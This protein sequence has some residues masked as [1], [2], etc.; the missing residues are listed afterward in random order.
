MLAELR[1][2]SEAEVISA[3]EVAKEMLRVLD[4]GCGGAVHLT[5]DVVH[6]VCNVETSR[7]AEE[8][9]AAH[10]LPKGGSPQGNGGGWV[11]LRLC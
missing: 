2:V 1:S 5:G 4:G 10:E 6:C 9:D 11:E 7:I 8:H 3:G